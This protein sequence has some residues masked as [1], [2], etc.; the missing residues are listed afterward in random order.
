MTSSN[1]PPTTNNSKAFIEDDDNPQR[2]S[3]G[4]IS[5]NK[6][7]VNVSLERQSKINLVD[8]AGSERA[9]ATGATGRRLRE[10]GNGKLLI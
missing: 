10:S 4:V 9:D 5:N 3:T 8:L 6:E 1:A 7:T 2:G